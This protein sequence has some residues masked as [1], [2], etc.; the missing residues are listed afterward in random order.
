MLSRADMSNTNVKLI[1]SFANNYYLILFHC[2]KDFGQ[3]RFLMSTWF[4]KL[5][6]AQQASLTDRTG[7]NVDAAQSYLRY[8]VLF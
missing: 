6:V 4:V 1:G 3:N 5:A 8:G 2:L 7:L